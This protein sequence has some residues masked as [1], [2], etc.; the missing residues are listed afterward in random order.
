MSN[1]F[2]ESRGRPKS[3]AA[4]ARTLRL[5]TIVAV[6]VCASRAAPQGTTSRA[7]VSSAAKEGDFE[8]GFPSL[9]ADGR[10]VAFRSLAG[11]LVRADSNGLLDAFVHDRSSGSTELVSATPSGAVGNGNS[12]WPALSADGRFVAFTS[13]ATNLAPDSN[14]FVQDVFVRDR[15]AKQTELVSRSS[16]GEQGDDWS[17]FPSISADG[18]HVAF[19]SSATNLVGGDVNGNA[20]IFVRDRDTGATSLVSVSSSGAQADNYCYFSA[21]SADGRYVAFDSMASTLVAGDTN[22][23]WDVFL[24]D[25]Q[26]NV[27]TCI[28]VSSSGVQGD[29]FSQRPAM[30]ADG[31]YVAFDSAARNLVPNDTNFTADIFLR[32]L[33]LGT[34]TRVSLSSGGLQAD[35]SS[36][37]AA[38]SADGRWVSFSSDATNLVPGDSN[39]KSDAF[40]RDV[41]TSTTSRVSLSSSGAQADGG[42]SRSALSA[43]GS[44]IA[45]D[46]LAANLVAGDANATSDMFLRDRAGCDPTVAK[47]CVAGASSSGCV[48]SISAA[49]TPSASAG[50]GFVLTVTSADGARTG[51]IFYGVAG[52]SL[53]PWSSSI[54]CV[55]PPQQRTPMQSTGGTTGACDGVL[56]LDWNAYVSQHPAAL[57]NPFSGIETVWAQA[58]IRDP[59][60][61]SANLSD[62]LWFQVCP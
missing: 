6:G 5:A 30:S 55:R 36:T 14:G 22:G 32:D 18:L 27:T 29:W 15:V 47:Y 60:A 3:N 20:D 39:H 37:F 49:G 2:V 17:T 13:S 54:L 41:L 21:I 11:T 35:Q 10:L 9:S 23:V 48:P 62:A 50:S 38:I 59:L 57:G 24:R 51:V 8:S 1:V 58:W 43:D 16:S 56:A 52:P 26:T 33:L 40:L 46:S 31:R 7:N 53:L 28:S 61:Q 25:R 34:T 44:W 12:E 42:S 19:S 45:F 4:R